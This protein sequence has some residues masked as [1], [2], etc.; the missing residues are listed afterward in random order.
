MQVQIDFNASLLM[1]M[2]P[3]MQHGEYEADELGML[4]ASALT[5][6]IRTAGRSHGTSRT[7]SADCS[8]G[9]LVGTGGTGKFYC[10]CG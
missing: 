7:R 3:V 4:L 1:A 10:F 9:A 2:E 6:Q 8:Q 5:R